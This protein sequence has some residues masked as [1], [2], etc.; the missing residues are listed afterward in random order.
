MP[1][2]KARTGYTI[3][4]WNREEGSA[5]YTPLDFLASSDPKTAIMPKGFRDLLRLE[6]PLAW[7]ELCNSGKVHGFR[8]RD[9]IE[10]N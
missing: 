6:C 5:D 2:L 7:K 8:F 1:H 10:G 4:Y 9:I 3:G